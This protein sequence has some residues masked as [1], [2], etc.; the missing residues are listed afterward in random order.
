MP[1][2]P[3]EPEA[4]RPVS[5]GDLTPLCAYGE[6]ERNALALVCSA[7]L[8]HQA[9]HAQKLH[10]FLGIGS[11]HGG[12]VVPEVRCQLRL[13]ARRYRERES[14]HSLLVW[15]QTC[16]RQYLGAFEKGNVLF[17]HRCSIG[18]GDDP[19]EETFFTELVSRTTIGV[20][21][22]GQ[23]AQRRARGHIVPGFTIADCDDDDEIFVLAGCR[24]LRSNCF[25]QLCHGVRAGHLMQINSGETRPG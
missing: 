5:L 11:R 7:P 3:V 2:E 6:P 4:Y 18:I 14:L 17:D 20:D 24:H 19:P 8:T 21:L 9:T 12:V 1:K 25:R 13:N 15:R 23:L 16:I 10:L 22:Q